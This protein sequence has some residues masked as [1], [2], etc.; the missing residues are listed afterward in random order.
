VVPPTPVTVHLRLTSDPLGST[1]RIDGQPY[2]TPAEVSLPVG[3]H[4]FEFEGGGWSTS[5]DQQIAEGAS[6]LKF[7]QGKQ[8]CVVF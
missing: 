2:T 7:S 8:G 5:C 1:V 3:A 4:H 6:K